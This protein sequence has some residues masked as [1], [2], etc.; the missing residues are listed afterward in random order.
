MSKLTVW[1]SFIA[2]FDQIYLA[3]GLLYAEYLSNLEIEFYSIQLEA[4]LPGCLNHLGAES[5]FDITLS[6]TPRF[7]NNQ[8]W[9]NKALFKLNSNYV[10]FRVWNL[11]YTDR[12]KIRHTLAFQTTGFLYGSGSPLSI[13]VKYSTD[14]NIP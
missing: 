1:N 9:S 5:D 14:L 3:A 4:D 12:A 8:F 7:S 10:V 11:L 6:K 13:H 2:L